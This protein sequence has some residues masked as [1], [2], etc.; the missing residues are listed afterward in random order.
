MRHDI[1]NTWWKWRKT[2]YKKSQQNQC[3]SFGNPSGQIIW[4][5]NKGKYRWQ[6]IRR[7]HI[8]LVTSPSYIWLVFN[9]V[10]NSFAVLS[11][12][13]LD[14][15]PVLSIFF[16]LHRYIHRYAIPTTLSV[17]EGIKPWFPVPME[18]ALTTTPR[19]RSNMCRIHDVLWL[20]LY[21]VFVTCFLALQ[22]IL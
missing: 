3:C 22:M 9:A 6:V 19:R 7:K 21:I 4:I 14:N 2:S 1:L 16:F 17:K 8:E 15:L 12:R 11:R 5:K 18:D 10:Y 20:K 13:F